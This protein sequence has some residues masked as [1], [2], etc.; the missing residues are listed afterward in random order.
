MDFIVVVLVLAVMMLPKDILPEEAVKNV[1]PLILTMFFGYE[2]LVGE[3]RGEM[4]LLTA[5][6]IG[7][8]V[9][10]SIRGLI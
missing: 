9:I 2:V 10:V 3:L 1:I 8:M 4:R 6:T 5:V 7:A